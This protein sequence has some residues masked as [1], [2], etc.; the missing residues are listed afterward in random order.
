MKGKDLLGLKDKTKEEIEEILSEAATMKKH[1]TDKT[2]K[3]PYLNNK[4]VV[5]L[6][7][8]N[9]TRTSLSF[10]TAAKMMSAVACNM[11][12]ANSSVSKGENLID[13]GKTIDAMGFD[14]I[15]IRHNMSGA[16][17]LLAKTVKA[18]VINAGD[19]QNEHPTQALLD[20]YTMKERFGAL[21]GLKVA[22]VGDVKHS[23]VARSNIWGL[24][25]MGTKV[26]AAGPQTLMPAEIEKMPVKIT[27]VEEAVKGADVVM[28]LRLQ[29]E[30]M[31]GGLIPSVAEYSKFYGLNKNLL[32]LAAKNAVVL[33]PGPVNRGIEITTE[34]CDS[35]ES[36]INTQVTNGL[37]VRMALLHLLTRGEQK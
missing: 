11:S 24:D 20:M 37:A 25:K 17:A 35:S 18:G 1:I 4:S 6:F 30:R 21:K 5:N 3:L 31:A 23:R 8:E 16:P 10:E 27:T 9:S 14:I 22:I 28:G 32:K 12:V 33:H 26:F 2:K 19:G 29:L 13:T 15:V 36:L 34:L 7:Y